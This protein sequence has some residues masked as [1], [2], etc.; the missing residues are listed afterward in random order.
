MKIGF[1]VDGFP[2]LSDTFILNQIT[3]LLDFGFEVTIFAH[4]NPEE[5]KTHPDVDKYRL[6]ERVRYVNCIPKNKLKRLFRTLSSTIPKF[7]RNPVS[8]LKFDIIRRIQQL[9]GSQ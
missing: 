5:P 9:S 1:I 4:Y 3:G 6:M 2:K 7:H 8:I